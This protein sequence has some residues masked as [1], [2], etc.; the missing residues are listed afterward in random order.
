MVGFA[1]AEEEEGCVLG[2]EGGQGLC[3]SSSSFLV[4][5][6][7]EDRGRSEGVG[8]EE[9]GVGGGGPGEGEEELTLLGCGGRSFFFWLHGCGSSVC[10]SVGVGWVRWMGVGVGLVG[11]QCVS[12]RVFIN[13]SAS[14]LQA[15]PPPPLSST[16]IPTRTHEPDT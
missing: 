10:C 7:E 16:G 5:E 3:V 13:G 14:A 15:L 11:Q 4:G 6:G 12:G 2:G 8:G 1:L 9:E